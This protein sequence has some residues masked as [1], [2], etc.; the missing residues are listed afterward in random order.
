MKAQAVKCVLHG[1]VGP[2]QENKDVKTGYYPKEVYNMLSKYVGTRAVVIIKDLRAGKVG[3]VRED[4]GVRELV[5]SVI[6]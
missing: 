5:D 3:N 6:L 2:H 1:I 4:G